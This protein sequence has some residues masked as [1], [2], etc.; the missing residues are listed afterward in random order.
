MVESITNNPNLGKTLG[1]GGAGGLLA[2]F[3][4]NWWNGQGFTFKITGN[5]VGSGVLGA[6]AELGYTMYTGAPPQMMSGII[7]GMLGGTVGYWL[8]RKAETMAVTY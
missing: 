5:L 6:A 2:P 3:V 7:V 4:I 8:F 1:Y